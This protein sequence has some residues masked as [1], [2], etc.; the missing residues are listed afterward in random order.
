LDLRWV[1]LRSQNPN[2]AGGSANLNLDMPVYP[3]KMID[4]MLVNTYS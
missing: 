4:G 3:F 1:G 2:G